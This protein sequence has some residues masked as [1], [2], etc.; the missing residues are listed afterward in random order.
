[1]PDGQQSPRQFLD[2]ETGEGSR[3][4]GAAWGADAIVC[5]D[6]SLSIALS[7]CV[8]HKRSRGLMMSQDIRSVQGPHLCFPQ[9]AGDRF[10]SVCYGW[11]VTQGTPLLFV[12]PSP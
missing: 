7:K 1:M 5:G 2:L 6:Y 12:C 11:H 9:P 8:C 4:Q 3:G 10:L